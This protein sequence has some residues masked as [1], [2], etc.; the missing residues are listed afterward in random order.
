MTPQG[1]PT[2]G[3]SRA[4]KDDASNFLS[5]NS[6]CVNLKSLILRF[7]V[8]GIFSPV[9]AERLIVL[10][11]RAAEKLSDQWFNKNR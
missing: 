10:L 9:L 5:P 2:T 7:A 1:K 4:G 6:L 3:G 8:W 11:Q